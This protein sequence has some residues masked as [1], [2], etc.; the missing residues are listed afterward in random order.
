MPNLQIARCA[1][2]VSDV[3]MIAAWKVSI[4]GLTFFDAIFWYSSITSSTTVFPAS[5][6]FL[7]STCTGYPFP[8]SS[9][10]AGRFPPLFFQH[11]GLNSSTTVSSRDGSRITSLPSFVTSS[12]KADRCQASVTS[13]SGDLSSFVLSLAVDGFRRRTQA[14]TYSLERSSPL[15]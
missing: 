10:D 9:F 15:I 4:Y 12:S 8:Y 5:G 7:K 14:V 1:L 13:D 2:T 11:Q 3:K 6:N